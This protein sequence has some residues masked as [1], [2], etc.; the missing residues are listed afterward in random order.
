MQDGTKAKA[1]FRLFGID[2]SIAAA[3]DAVA[4]LKP[5]VVVT[6]GSRG[7]GLALA[8]RFLQAGRDVAIVARNAPALDTAVADLKTATGRDAV[9]IICD[10]AEPNAYEVIA[11]RLEEAGFYLDVLIN[12][13][14]VGLAG[15][16]AGNDQTDID[17][18]LALNVGAVTRLTRA[19]LPALIARRSGGIL[20]MASLGAYVPGPNQAVHYA[21]KSYIVSLTE[22]LA[23]EAS[24]KGVRICVVAPG[25]VKTGFHTDMGAE[26]S[27]YRA[28]IP[29]LSPE[30]VATSAYFG[31]QAGMRAVVPGIFNKAMFLVVR[32]LPHP[33]T[34]PFVYWLLKRRGH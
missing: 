16:F 34:V 13:A 27:L 4:H 31:Y 23:S 12:N 6:G 25:P 17:R 33:V 20:N 7:I 15:A 26:D 10:V 8:K 24:G 32:A 29:A 2:E 5:A 11:G 1:R 21:S 3:R 18:L 28:I 9:A 14:G 19:A 22:A 30:S